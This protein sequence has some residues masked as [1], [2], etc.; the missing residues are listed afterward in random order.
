MLV[1]IA[2]LL[3]AALASE[4]PP[5]ERTQDTTDVAA[6]APVP[7][8]ARPGSLGSTWYCAA[9]TATGTAQGEAEQFLHMANASSVDRART[10]HGVPERRRPGDQ[11]DRDRTACAS[12]CASQ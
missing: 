3:V 11:R 5:A 10:A 1:I 7:T 12:R 2:V 9:G 6:I 8:A 4:T